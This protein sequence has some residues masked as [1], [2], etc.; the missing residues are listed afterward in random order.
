MADTKEKEM[1]FV[2]DNYKIVISGS[3]EE[4]D[5]VKK[6]LTFESD[7]PNFWMKYKGKIYVRFFRIGA[8]GAIIVK[9]GLLDYLLKRFTVDVEDRRTCLPAPTGTMDVTG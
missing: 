5:E 7:K 2:V 4:L 9:S 6:V 1:K 8:E 3:T